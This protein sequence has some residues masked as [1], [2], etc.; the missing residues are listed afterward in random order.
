MKLAD[1][2][3]T[4]VVTATLTSVFWIVVSGTVLDRPSLF[5]AGADPSPSVGSADI[6][7]K[8]QAA[9]PPPTAPAR[10]MGSAAG[11]NGALRIPVA[12]VPA[13]ALVDTFT[14]SRGGGTRPHDAIDIMAPTGTPVVAAAN[15]VVEKLFLSQDGGKTIYV[16]LPGGRTLHYYAHLDQYA[17][18]LQEG[19]PV[20]AGQR[21]GTVG[22]SGNAD[23][24]APHLHF[25]ILQR[26]PGA[27]WHS[28]TQ[29][30]NPYPLLN[31][32]GAQAR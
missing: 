32:R 9:S 24:A 19:M 21:L 1:R 22:F 27:S 11:G 3:Q 26:Q 30:T 23:P 13:S 5:G 2:L 17:P 10:L 31:P 6:A 25:A 14:Q 29:A 16:R 7:A 4:I 18:G 20:A 12:G 8:G 15:G 28:Q